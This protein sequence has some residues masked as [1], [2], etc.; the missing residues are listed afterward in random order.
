MQYYI[1][2]LIIHFTPNR[3]LQSLVTFSYLIKDIISTMVTMVIKAPGYSAE[4]YNA[5]ARAFWDNVNPRQRNPR[6]G[7]PRTKY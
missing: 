2:K 6:Q 4:S 3:A 5:T 1:T 7:D